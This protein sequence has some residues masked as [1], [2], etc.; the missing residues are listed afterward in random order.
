[1][2]SIRRPEGNSKKTLRTIHAVG[3][4]DE[5]PEELV[6]DL[7]PEGYVS[8]GTA[9]NVAEAVAE[10]VITTAAPR[11]PEEAVTLDE[12]IKDTDVSRSTANRVAKSL[13]ARGALLTLGAGKKGNPFRYFLPEG[14][15]FQTSNTGEKHEKNLQPEPGP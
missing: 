13:C 8:L 14:F 10:Q 5:T 3:R 7:T 6:I 4:F 9:A 12:L 11:T 1:V 15:S 2:L